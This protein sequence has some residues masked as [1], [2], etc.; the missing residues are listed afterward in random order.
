MDKFIDR[1]ENLLC[2]QDEYARL[3]VEANMNGC[4]VDGD[5]AILLSEAKNRLLEEMA[6]S[7]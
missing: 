1:I 4:K 2:A 7:G 3:L 5:I 6:K